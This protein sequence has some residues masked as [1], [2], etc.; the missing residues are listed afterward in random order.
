[1]KEGVRESLRSVG[2]LGGWG[3]LGGNIIG[4]CMVIYGGCSEEKGDGGNEGCIA[5]NGNCIEGNGDGI[6]GGIILNAAGGGL[7]P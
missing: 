1:M 4:G 6:C 3:K 7:K 2:R 5:G